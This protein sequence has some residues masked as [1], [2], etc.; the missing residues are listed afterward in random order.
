MELFSI[1]KNDNV[2][3]GGYFLFFKMSTTSL[4]K[5]TKATERN[6]E[7]SG[8]AQIICSVLGH[9]EVDVYDH[10]QDYRESSSYKTRTF[11]IHAE[12]SVEIRYKGQLVFRDSGLRA[13][14][15]HGD[16]EK[17]FE[18]LYSRAA[19]KAGRTGLGYCMIDL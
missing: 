1:V 3:I 8:M 16:W 17:S 7:F 10:G 14:F 13:Y 11:E 5:I 9:S 19:N 2:F 15:R 18:R 6:D 12:G 4:E